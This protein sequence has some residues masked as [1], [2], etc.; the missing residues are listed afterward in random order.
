[1]RNQQGMHRAHRGGRPN[2]LRSPVLQGERGLPL[3]SP[4]VSCPTCGHDLDLH[5]PVTLRCVFVKRAWDGF[6]Y[7]KHGCRCSVS[8]E[9]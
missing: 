2:P 1:M 7:T 5:S 6:T 4:L 9:G 3:P 8:E